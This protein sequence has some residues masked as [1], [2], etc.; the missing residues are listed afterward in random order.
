MFEHWEAIRQ[1]LLNV[2]IEEMEPATYECGMCSE[3]TPDVCICHDC[4][5]LSYYCV[6]CCKRFHTKMPYHIPYVWKVRTCD[7]V[8]DNEYKIGIKASRSAS[9][10]HV[11]CHMKGGYEALCK[12]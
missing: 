6:S 2:H 9:H 12:S 1:E 8:Y 11:K 7:E 10:L 3:I 4:G 5:P